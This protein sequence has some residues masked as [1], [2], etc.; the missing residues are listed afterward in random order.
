M[1]KPPRSPPRKPSEI[2]KKAIP[3]VH[4]PKLNTSITKKAYVYYGPELPLAHHI[5]RFEI[6]EENPPELPRPENI[7]RF[8]V[9]ESLE[10]PRTQNIGRF[11]VTESVELPR[12]QNI[13]RFQLIEHP[14][15][16][17]RKSRGWSKEK[18]SDHERT[19]MLKR[20]GRKCF[21]GPGKSFPVRKKGTCTISQRSVHAA[22]GRARQWKHTSVVKKARRLF[23]KDSVKKR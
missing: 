20:C 4:Y 8:H 15:L 1:S 23:S 2:I 14:E 16:A 11:N 5:G 12:T 3:R 6:Y 10:L 22:Y 18:P 9:T 19:V 7:G 21:L 17:G 13:G